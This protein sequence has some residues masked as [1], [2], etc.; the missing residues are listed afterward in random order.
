MDNEELILRLQSLPIE[1]EL[2]IFYTFIY[3]GHFLL[4]FS[5]QMPFINGYI[6]FSKFRK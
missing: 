3:W 1:T 4:E 5:H 2:N 6:I